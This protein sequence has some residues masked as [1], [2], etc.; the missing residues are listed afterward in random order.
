MPL[1]FSDRFFKLWDRS[2]DVRQLDDV[3][4]RPFRQFAEGGKG[5]DGF[6]SIFQIVRKGRQNSSRKRNVRHFD[7]D[8]RSSCKGLYD[9]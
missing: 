5:I 4:L 9:R 2:R 3:G 6:L 7:L 1:Q 8:I